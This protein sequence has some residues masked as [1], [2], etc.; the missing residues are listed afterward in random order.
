MHGKM[1]RFSIE[2][3]SGQ[4][5]VK[6]RYNYCAYDMGSHIVPTIIVPDL[7]YRLAKLWL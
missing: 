1:F 3:Q 7:N 4:L 5:V 6:I 2:P